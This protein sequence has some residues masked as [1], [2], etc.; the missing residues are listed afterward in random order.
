MLPSLPQ[1]LLCQV[2]VLPHSRLSLPPQSHPLLSMPSTCVS[3][4]ALST[5]PCHLIYFSQWALE[6]EGIMTEGSRLRDVKGS[7][8]CHTAHRRQDWPKSRVC[9]PLL[10]DHASC[11]PR[12]PGHLSLRQKALAAATCLCS[13]LRVRH[14]DSKFLSGARKRN[15]LELAQIREVTLGVWRSQCSRER[16]GPELGAGV[17]ARLRSPGSLSRPLGSL[18]ASPTHLRPPPSMPF[19]LTTC[20]VAGNPLAFHLSSRSQPAASWVSLSQGS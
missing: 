6:R 9:V 15:S 4:T 3:D 7:P 5:Y 8:Q 12:G 14:C 19:V 2:P 16:R 20:S 1:A 11:S 18:S 17:C 13:D 10:S